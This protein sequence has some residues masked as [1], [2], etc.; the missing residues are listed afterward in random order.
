M[1]HSPLSR[2]VKAVSPLWARGRAMSRLRAGQ[3]RPS[4]ALSRGRSRFAIV[5]RKGKIA[6]FETVGQLDPKTSA[7]MPKDAIFRLYS[8]TD[9]VGMYLRQRAGRGMAGDP[10][11]DPLAAGA[12]AGAEVGKAPAA[13]TLRRR[14]RTPRG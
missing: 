6:Y 5:A 2:T 9:P 10:G 14:S 13:V 7:P 1:L 11:R 8:M 4:R 3:M 12:R